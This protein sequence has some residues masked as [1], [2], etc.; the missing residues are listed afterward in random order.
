MM[1][2]YII[3][4]YIEEFIE[5][6]NSETQDI[7]DY[8]EYDKADTRLY[9]K[10]IKTEKMDDTITNIDKKLEETE[11]A[12]REYESHLSF[13]IPKEIYEFLDDYGKNEIYQKYVN[14]KNIIFKSTEKIIVDNLE[15]N[16][17]EFKNAYSDNIFQ[18]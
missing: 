1:N 14:I 10:D 7:L 16:S 17:K 18:N 4:P 3:N 15:V 9:L 12:I 13:N 2:S 6:L 8:I 5:K 11:N